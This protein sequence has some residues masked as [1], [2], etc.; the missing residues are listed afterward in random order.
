MHEYLTENEVREKF[1]YQRP[2]EET[3][4]YVPINFLI[5]LNLFFCFEVFVEHMNLEVFLHFFYCK[6]YSFKAC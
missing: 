2:V 4:R 5:Q 6:K 3:V 1:E